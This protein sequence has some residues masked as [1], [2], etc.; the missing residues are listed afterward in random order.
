LLTGRRV[1][2]ATGGHGVGTKGTKSLTTVHQSAGQYV[3]SVF[4][5]IHNYGM[6][7]AFFSSSPRD[8]LIA[9][10]WGPTYG[11]YDPYGF[12]DG[13]NKIDT[14][15]LAA[16]DRDVVAQAVQQISK[17]PRH[18]SVISLSD[19]YRIGREYGVRSPQF[20]VAMGTVDTQISQ[21]RRAIKATRA[22]KHT[23][24]VVVGTTGVTR[25]H[26]LDNQ[27]PGN[28]RIPVIVTGP[29]VTPADL[30]AINPDRTNPGRR[31]ADYAGTPQPIRN[32][33]LSNLLTQLLSLPAIPGTQA[34]TDQ[35][36]SLVR[37]LD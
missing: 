19:P 35:S 29:G 6:T 27:W 11:G 3:S 10:T 4:D 37:D 16:T 15:S 28:Y 24:L 34:N 7:T 33:D 22:G 20:E 2:P 32:L 14:L 12:D 36:L 31:Q 18:L 5:L 8:S 25:K 13:R 17:R 23:V 1:D 30:Y 21:I 26:Y 9:N